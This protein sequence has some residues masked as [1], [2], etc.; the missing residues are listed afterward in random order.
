MG[1]VTRRHFIA[2]ATFAAASNF[3]IAAQTFEFAPTASENG[4]YQVS[5]KPE[6]AADVK[7]GPIHVWLLSVADN[8]G[9]PV[10]GA[11][12][13]VDGGMSAHGHG[14]PTSPAVIGEPEPGTYRIDGVK[15]S[16]GGTWQLRFEIEAPAGTDRVE[17]ELKL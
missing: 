13:R 2:I 11:S 4:L 16:M 1:L 14:L 12:I 3:A 8:R 15:F 17:F 9:Q 6:N 10:T 5:L 7:V